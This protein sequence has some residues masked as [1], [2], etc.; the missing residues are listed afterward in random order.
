MRANPAFSTEQA[1]TELAVGEGLISFLDEKGRPAIVQR[2]YVLPPASRIGPITPDERK[3][4]I[5][6]SPVAGVYDKTID[7]ESAYERLQQRA[8]RPVPGSAVP[9]SG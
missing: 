5:H 4:V 1:I 3:A 6:Q 9:S 2:A 8:S 7:R